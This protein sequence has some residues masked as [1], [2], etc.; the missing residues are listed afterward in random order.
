MERP[1]GEKSEGKGSLVN[2]EDKLNCEEVISYLKLFL[3]TH[4]RV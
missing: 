2:E 3:E 4:S 1:K